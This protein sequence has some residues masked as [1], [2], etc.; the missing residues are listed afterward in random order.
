MSLYWLCLFF[1]IFH[2]PAPLSWKIKIWIENT[3]DLGEVNPRTFI[4]PSQHIG[5]ESDIVTE[6][7]AVREELNVTLYPIH[8]KSHQDNDPN[9]KPTLGVQLNELCDAH[10]KLF[11]HTVD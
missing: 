2:A 5:Q 11:L 10:A 1:R 4:T 7:L 6:I 9:A 3:S 8:V